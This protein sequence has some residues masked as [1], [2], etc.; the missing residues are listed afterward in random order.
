MIDQRTAN[1]DFQQPHPS[2]RLDEDVPRLRE[3]I[4][5]IDNLLFWAAQ[6]IDSDDPLGTIPA[7]VTAAKEAKADILQLIPADSAAF[8]Y[9]AEGRVAQI[10]ETLPGGASRATTYAY[11]GSALS[12]ETVVCDGVTRRTTYSYLNGRVSSTTRVIL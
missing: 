1:F 11:S 8:A 2:N 10:T 3:T 4:Q 9:D 6:R 12:S 5:S 7:L